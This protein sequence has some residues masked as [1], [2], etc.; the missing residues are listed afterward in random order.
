MYTHTYIYTYIYTCMYVYTCT[1]TYIHTCMH[2][3]MHTYIHA[4]IHTYIRTYIHA[5]IHKEGKVWGARSHKPNTRDSNKQ[6]YDSPFPV[7]ALNFLPY[8]VL[9]PLLGP[10]L[11]FCLLHSLQK[12]VSLF[13]RSLS[14]SACFPAF[15]IIL[16]WSFIFYSNF[17][18]P[19]SVCRPFFH[20]S[21]FSCSLLALHSLLLFF[22]HLY[23]FLS[24]LPFLGYFHLFA[25]YFVFI[26][27]FSPSLLVLFPSPVFKRSQESH[28]FCAG[29]HYVCPILSAERQVSY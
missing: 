17:F 1:H 7:T 12:S 4:Y 26:T 29:W 10:V 28:I 9:H 19:P 20:S 16:F 24:S 18:P 8:S 27:N 25:L 23:Y 6:H 2:T 3:Y 15:F 11:F 22:L 13:K 5:Y 14:L 21:Y